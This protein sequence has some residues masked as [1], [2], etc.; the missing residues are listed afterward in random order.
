MEM[1]QW[2]IQNETERNI[3]LIEISLN[4]IHIYIRRVWEQNLIIG[5]GSDR[6][7]ESLNQPDSKS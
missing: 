1:S 6:I 7:G 5:E 4:I 3:Y 2:E